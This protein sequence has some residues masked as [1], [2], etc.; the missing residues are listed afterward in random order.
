MPTILDINLIDIDK[1]LK[2][3]NSAKSGHV[4]KNEELIDLK[5][6]INNSMVGLSKLLHFMNPTTYAIWDS[7]I[8]RFTTGKEKSTYGIDR[9]QLY[10]DY[11]EKLR[12][13]V[14]NPGFSSIHE[15]IQ[16]TIKYNISPFRIVDIIIFEADKRKNA[17]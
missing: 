17:T 12:E 15:K 3:F 14:S 6:C 9:P 5:E 2:L 11:L 10:L 16:E 1:K 8:F 4:L 13:I 7:R